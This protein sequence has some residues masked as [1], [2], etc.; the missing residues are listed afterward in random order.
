MVGPL[1][2]SVGG[3]DLFMKTVIDSKP[4]LQDPTLLPIPWRSDQV[5]RSPDGTR[6]LKIGVMWDDGIV[7]PHPPVTRALREVVHHLNNM[8]GMKVVNWTPYKHDLAWK[9]IVYSHLLA[10]N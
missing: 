10:L 8:K 7:K 3:L 2:T 6:I 9:I 1:S 5:K 4:W